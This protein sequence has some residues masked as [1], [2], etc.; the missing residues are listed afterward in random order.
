MSK[1]EP[2]A[3]QKPTANNYTKRHQVSRTEILFDTDRQSAI[4]LVI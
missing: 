4:H 3:S 2:L 1:L